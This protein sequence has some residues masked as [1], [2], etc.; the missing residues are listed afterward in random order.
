MSPHHL[1]RTFKRIMDVS[2]YQYADARRLGRLKSDLR[3][4][5]DIA[6]A[7]YGAGY[8]SSSRLYEKAPGQ[9]GMTPATYRKGGAG[10]SM[11]YA[12]VD[13]AVGRLLVAATD[14]GLSFVGFGEADADIEAEMRDEFPAAEITR[15]D[16]ALGGLVGPL[17]ASLAGQA[18]A[19]ELALDVQATAFQRR[20]WE[21]LRAIPLGEAR[22]Y[23]E[24][25]EILGQ[26][27]AARAVGN[28]CA[29]NPVPLV[30][31]GQW[32]VRG[33]SG[34]DGYRWG[35][36]RKETLPARE[37]HMAKEATS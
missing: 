33:D 28:A 4:G 23:R 8:A 10:A 24:V 3:K 26:P 21:A 20:V 36:G 9:L 13:S 15:D 1:Q 17:V 16:D 27:G 19:L 35:P 30:I 34:L 25:A 12:I 5:E 22:T 14:R 37:R 2:P 31:P 7:L 11:R 29:H 18:G 32:V 6:A